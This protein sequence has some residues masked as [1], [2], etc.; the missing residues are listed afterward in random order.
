MRPG[1]AAESEPIR[2]RPGDTEVVLQL[3]EG[4]ALRGMVVDDSSGEPCRAR[5]LLS[6]SDTSDWSAG[7]DTRSDGT[8]EL[9]GLHDG[10]YCLAASTPDGRVG[11]LRGLA[12][13]GASTVE[14]LRIE[15]EPGASVRIRY[16]GPRA[17]QVFDVLFRD[18][19]T[20][21]EGIAKGTEATLHAVAGDVVVR[22]T[23]YPEREHLDLPL[24]LRVGETRDVV[25]D[26]AWK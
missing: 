24:T 3:R 6:R 20:A 11:I 2:V 13:T 21:S 4:G 23:T 5:L 7:V 9:D 10:S 15:V 26:G 14:G 18:A 22:A 25:F 12:I 1:R 16:E 17:R 19:C 8:F